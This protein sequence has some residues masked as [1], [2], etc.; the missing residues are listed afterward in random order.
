MKLLIVDDHAVV[1]EGVSAML[2]QAEPSTV[3]LQAG[4]TVEGLA[5][6]EAHPD[7]DAV[8]LDLAMPGIGGIAA[9]KE[10]GRRRS[11]VPVI[12]LSASEDPEDIHRALA[13]GALGYVPKSARPQTFLSA[14]QLVLSGEVYLPPLLLDRK[15]SPPSRTR[16][17]DRQQGIDQ[18]TER[19]VEVLRWLG[20][21]ISN[22]EIGAA[23]SL[24]EKTV[25][26]HVTAIFRT[27]D[28]VNRTQAASIARQAELI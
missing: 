16:N 6:A 1:R 11:D 3:V 26:A 23:L 14:L 18:L 27:L 13:S 5:L 20:R 9:I 28:V 19:Q 22:K 25:K 10:F 8:L 15:M 2:L 4:T 7:L 17:G 24:S 12:V 21:G